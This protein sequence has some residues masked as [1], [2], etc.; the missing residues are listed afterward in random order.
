ML[1]SLIIFL[2]FGIYG[3]S[4]A[5]MLQFP[6]WAMTLTIMLLTGSVEVRLAL[7]LM[8]SGR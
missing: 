3:Y 6:T 4:L 1:L 7:A 8:Q 5:S 2:W